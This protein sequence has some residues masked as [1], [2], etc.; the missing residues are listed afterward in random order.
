MNVT[1][2]AQ[3]QRLRGLNSMNRSIWLINFF[4]FYGKSGRQMFVS[5]NVQRW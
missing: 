3:V 4:I 1:F 2:G 5:S